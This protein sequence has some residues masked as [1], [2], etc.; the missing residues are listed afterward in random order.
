ALFGQNA[1]QLVSGGSVTASRKN[2]LLYL[3]G[4]AFFDRGLAVAVEIEQQFFAI[5]RRGFGRGE[6]GDKVMAHRVPIMRDGAVGAAHFQAP[7]GGLLVCHG[8]AAIVRWPA[9][10]VT[11]KKGV[12][13]FARKVIKPRMVEPSCIVAAE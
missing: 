11:R 10:A 8:D 7:S 3:F 12:I 1:R 9:R 13:D 5:P 4:P 2:I 6:S